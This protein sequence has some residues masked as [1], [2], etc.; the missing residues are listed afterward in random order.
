MNVRYL[1]WAAT[2]PPDTDILQLIAR[3]SAETFGNP[4]S[5]HP[6]GRSA[7]RV[8]TEAREAVAGLIGAEADQVVF[9]SG[10]TESNLTVLSSLLG[11]RH[12][13]LVTTSLEHASCYEPAKRLARFGTEVRF[14]DARETGIVSPDQVAGAVDEHTAMVSVMLVN[15]ETGAVQ[16]IREIVTAVRER[17]RRLGRPVHIH[18]DAVQALGKLP[19]HLGELGVD[20]A[21]ASAHKLGGPRGVGLLYLRAPL[22]TP[23]VGGGQEHGMR[24]GTENVAGNAGFAEAL[25]G[26]LSSVNE[27]LQHARSLTDAIMRELV[28]F[29]GCRVNPP[30]RLQSPEAFSPYILNLAFPPVPGEVLVRVLGDRGFA[31]STGSACSSRRKKK[32]RVLEASGV[33]SEA[34]ASSLRISVGYSTSMDDVTAFCRT[35]KQELPLLMKVAR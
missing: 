32:T 29:E 16:P 22:D 20:S 23:A 24:P 27:N 28:G 6:V 3:L 5:Q 35:V 14:L 2:A 18:T 10:G 17:S 15:N 9:S 26:R 21:S 30:S 11:R 34:A 7:E 13:G 25:S 1:D 19:L 4:S 31:V 8:L 12:A 33:A